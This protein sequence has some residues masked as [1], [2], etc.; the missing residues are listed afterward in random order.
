[1]VLITIKINSESSQGTP[2]ELTPSQ[3]HPEAIESL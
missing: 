2:G 3:L 1:M